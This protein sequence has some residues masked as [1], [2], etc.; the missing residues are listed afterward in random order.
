MGTMNQKAGPNAFL[1]L[2]SREINKRGTLLATLN[3]NRADEE[4]PL[5]RVGSLKIMKIGKIRVVRRVDCSK[6]IFFFYFLNLLCFNLDDNDDRSKIF[7]YCEI[8]IRLF[9][10]WFSLVKRLGF[11]EFETLRLMR[12]C[13]FIK[14]EIS[15]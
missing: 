7:R 4:A 13:Y 14:L 5:P 3:G 11:E 12:T 1:A 15:F 2:V 8:F 9:P 10:L 6:F